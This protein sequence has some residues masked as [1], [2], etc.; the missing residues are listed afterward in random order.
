[1]VLT[2]AAI[3]FAGAQGKV[4]SVD[5]NDVLVSVEGAKSGM[6]AI[7]L[8]EYKSDSTISARCATIKAEKTTAT[9]KC[10]PFNLYDQSSAPTLTLPIRKGD[11]AIFTPLGSSAIVIAPDLD[12]Y[13]KARRADLTYVHSDL[14]AH[15]L[16]TDDVAKPTI[17]DF[18][19]FCDRLLVGA[20]VFAFNDGDYTVDCQTFAILEIAPYSAAASK[21]SI[22]PF[23]HRLG[24]IDNE[25]GDFDAYY[26]RLIKEF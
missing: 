5:Q 10:S 7:I 1:M 22:L 9:L 4:I 13:V 3:A 8:Y 11:K 12:R 21:K 23:F 2:F 17:A 18:R 20:V 24:A 25:I 14:F 6:S 26:K 16:V 15:Q 19:R